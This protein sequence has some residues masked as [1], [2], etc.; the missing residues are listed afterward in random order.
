MTSLSKFIFRKRQQSAN[1]SLL[2]ATIWAIEDKD[3]FSQLIKHLKDFIDDLEGFT[4]SLDV[5]R[6]QQIYVQYEIESIADT[7]ILEDIEMAK[8]GDSDVVS[9]TATQYLASI[10]E[11]SVRTMS[12]RT[13]TDSASFVTAQESFSARTSLSG[14]RDFEFA[15]SV[16]FPRQLDVSKALRE[17]PENIKPID[18]AILR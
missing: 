3:K 14:N 17:A 16:E 11:G 6:R 13:S 9:D 12:I 8:E 2:S 7:S 1:N 5:P 15:S 18:T 10:R 4:R